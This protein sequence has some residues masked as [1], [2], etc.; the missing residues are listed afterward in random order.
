M[1]RNIKLIHFK[2]FEQLELNCKQ[3]NLLCGLNG[4]G[5]RQRYPSVTY[6]PTIV[7]N[8]RITRWQTGLER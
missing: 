7:Q 4:M 8:W 5:K 2:C 3:L 1:L 6:A